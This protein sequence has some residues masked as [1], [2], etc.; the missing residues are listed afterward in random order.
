MV[1][2]GS[3]PWHWASRGTIF[4][5]CVIYFYYWQIIQAC[6]VRCFGTFVFWLEGKKKCFYQ[7]EVG[8]CSLVITHHELISGFQTLVQRARCVERPYK[9]ID[10]L[11]NFFSLPINQHYFTK[12]NM[13]CHENKICYQ[14]LK[15]SVTIDEFAFVIPL[16][17][18]QP[19][20]TTP[21]PPSQFWAQEPSNS[22]S[23]VFNRTCC[24]TSFK[25]I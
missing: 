16:V 22:A 1:R 9:D 11:Y 3:V 8:N 6:L 5:E 13:W 21:F 7:R 20:S 23:D 25:L 10:G 17:I 14:Q 15:F 2:F 24:S 19:L 4:S 18:P 12:M